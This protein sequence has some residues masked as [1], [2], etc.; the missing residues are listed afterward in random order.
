M[1]NKILSLFLA[2]S[3]FVSCATNLNSIRLP[4]AA[5]DE[6]NYYLSID[7]FKYYLN[8]YTVALDGKVPDE[9]LKNLRALT[10]E[11]LIKMHIDPAILSDANN[12]DGLIYDY[13]HFHRCA[14]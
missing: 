1:K 2:L 12:Y 5:T 4:A 6:I 10:V 8:E 13:S 7:K 11:D 9:I 14:F 3:L